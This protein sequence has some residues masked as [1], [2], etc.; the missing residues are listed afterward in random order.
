MKAVH[1]V[2]RSR[3]LRFALLPGCRSASPLS[4]AMTAMRTGT[5]TSWGMSVVRRSV[6][7]RIGRTGAVLSAVLSLAALAACVGS[8]R[9]ESAFDQAFPRCGEPCHLTRN[10]GGELA[11]FLKA[12]EEVGNGAR[13][14]VVIDGACNSSCAVFA[15]RARS[16]VCITQNAQFGFH[17][18]NVYNSDLSQQLA[19][20]DPPH[21]DDI[22]GWVQS[23]GGFPTSGMLVM[24][25]ETASRFWRLCTPEERRAARAI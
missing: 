21:S 17:R 22:S 18:A 8:P 6:G 12:A 7:G 11:I 1:A 4:G 2:N 15:D 19:K 14:L 23:E 16:S 5:T 20:V 3:D 25:A 24:T 13:R 9:A 10:D